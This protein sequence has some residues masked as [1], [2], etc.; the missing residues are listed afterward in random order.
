MQYFDRIVGIGAIVLGATALSGCYA[1]PPTYPVAAVPPPSGAI[2]A[3][4][5]A[6]AIPSR[7]RSRALCGGGELPVRSYSAIRAD[8]PAGRCAEQR[9][10][11]GRPCRPLW[12]AAAARRGPAADALADGVLAARPLELERRTIRVDAGTLCT[13]PDADRQLGPRLLAA[14][15]RRLDVGRGALGVV[16]RPR[17]HPRRASARSI[18]GRRAGAVGSPCSTISVRVSHATSSASSP[19]TPSPDRQAPMTATRV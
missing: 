5:R 18:S 17:G 13:T 14:R 6:G 19:G 16:L 12:P 2:P 10:H 15:A 9:R 1:P 8:D 11:D 4:D 7:C 3:G